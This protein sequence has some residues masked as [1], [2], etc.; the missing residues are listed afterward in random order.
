[1]ILLILMDLGLVVDSILDLVAFTLHEN[2]V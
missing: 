1:M 2:L